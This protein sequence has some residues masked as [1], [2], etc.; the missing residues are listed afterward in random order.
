[1]IEWKESFGAR[2]FSNNFYRI[3]FSKT[4]KLQSILNQ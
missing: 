2:S 4:D 1:L 3:D